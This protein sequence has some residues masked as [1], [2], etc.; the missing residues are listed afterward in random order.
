ML[1]YV[2]AGEER[3]GVVGRIVPK[4]SDVWYFQASNLH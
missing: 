4:D 1:A 3:G 2:A